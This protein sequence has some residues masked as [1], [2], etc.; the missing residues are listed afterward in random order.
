[1]S[2]ALITGASSGLGKELARIHAERG[3]DLI[4][5]AR[6]VEKLNDLK[7]EL[8]SKHGVR[9]Y[10]LPKDLSKW[11]APEEIYAELKNENIPF[12]ILRNCF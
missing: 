4:I 2:T 10:V 6:S 5:V 1:M 7:R 9:V 11:T 3:G 12:D 8:E